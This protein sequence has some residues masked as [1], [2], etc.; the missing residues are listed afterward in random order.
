MHS[1]IIILSCLVS[2]DRCLVVFSPVLLAIL[3]GSLAHASK[4]DQDSG[5]NDNR[6]SLLYCGLFCTP[7]PGKDQLSLLLLF[8]VSSIIVPISGLRMHA[9]MSFAALL[10]LE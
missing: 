2:L 8:F 4:F 7:G 3:A 6:E 5:C 10:L 9:F 1:L